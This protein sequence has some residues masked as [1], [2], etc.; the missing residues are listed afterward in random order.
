MHLPR[1][2]TRPSFPS[3]LPW[4]CVLNIH[5]ACGRMPAGDP[6]REFCR[7][8]FTHAFGH[9]LAMYTETKHTSCLYIRGRKKNKQKTQALCIQTR[10]F[11]YIQHTTPITHLLSPVIPVQDKSKQFAGDFIFPTRRSL[12]LS[13]TAHKLITHFNYHVYTQT[14]FLICAFC[15]CSLLFLQK[16]MPK[17]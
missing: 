5:F 11:L 17:V 13:F 8:V 15:L 14:L 1:S 4:V 6:R 7:P 16:V 10:S 2:Q 9:I 3:F 12:Q